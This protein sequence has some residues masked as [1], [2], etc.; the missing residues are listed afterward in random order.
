MKLRLTLVFLVLSILCGW[1]L[2][3]GAALGQ[4][5]PRPEPVIRHPDRYDQDFNGII[6]ALDQLISQEMTSGGAWHERVVVVTLWEPCSQ[7]HLDQ[8]R[9]LG[10]RIGCV[11]THVCYGFAARLPVWAIPH[12][13]RNLGD[14]LCII[15]SPTRG[16][17]CMDVAS[18][19]LR[20]RPIVWDNY[21]FKGDPWSS[22]AVIDTGI[23]TAHNDLGDPDRDN[24]FDDSDDWYD[25][26][27]EYHSW[28]FINAG[29]NESKYK[30]VGWT[31][32]ENVWDQQN[33]DPYDNPVDP[34]CNKDGHGTH[35]S[36]ILS[37]FG[38]VDSNYKGIA[39][40]TRLFGERFDPNDDDYSKNYAEAVAAMDD[41][42]GWRK[43][44]YRIR[45]CNMSWYFHGDESPTL[46]DKADTMAYWG[47][48][49]V[50]SAGNSDQQNYVWDPGRSQMAIT[51]GATNDYD[52]VT[53]YSVSSYP[54]D[55]IKPDVVAPGGSPSNGTKIK[56]CDNN[57]DDAY[58]EMYG[59][60]MAAPMVSGEAALV[61]QALGLGGDASGWDHD[62]NTRKIK[63]LIL[64]T[65]WET[66]AGETQGRT[67][68][69]NRGGKDNIE[70]YGRVCPD[71]AVEAASMTYTVGLTA[72]GGFGSQPE[73]KKVWAR[74]LSF[75]PSNEDCTLRLKMPAYYDADLYV[76]RLDPDEHGEPVILYK[77]TSS[78]EGQT[79][80]IVRP[81][82]DQG[83][84]AYVV[85][86]DATPPP[87]NYSY[88]YDFTLEASTASNKDEVWIKDSDSDD[89]TV[90]CLKTSSCG[91]PS[92]VLW[93]ITPDIRTDPDPPILGLGCEIYVT[94]RNKTDH[95][96]TDATVD[97]YLYEPT[98]DA[99]IPTS[100]ATQTWQKTG[101]T[102]PAEGSVEV[103]PFVWGDVMNNSKG[104]PYWYIGAT[105]T[106]PRD[107]IRLGCLIFGEDNV[108][109]KRIT[110]E[111]LKVDMDPGIPG[112]GGH[113]DIH[114]TLSVP[115]TAMVSA[116]RLA[117]P[118]E[119]G[120]YIYPPLDMP[121]ELGPGETITG[122]M[123]LYPPVSSSMGVPGV[124]DLVSSLI[125]ADDSAEY[126]L[127]GSMTVG[128]CTDE[129]FSDESMSDWIVDSQ[130]TTVYADPGNFV[131]PPCSMRID[132]SPAQ[133]AYAK[134]TSPSI[135][136]DLTK[137]YRLTFSMNW[138][139]LY[140]VKL[141]E[142]GHIRLFVRGQGQP[143]E[144]SPDGDWSH[145][146]PIGPPFDS[147]LPPGVWGDVVVAVDPAM[148]CYKIWVGG[149]EVGTAVY[150][151]WL[152]PVD[153]LQIEDQAASGSVLAANF[154]DIRPVGTPPGVEP[155]VYRSS[156]PSDWINPR[157]NMIS[158]PLDPAGSWDASAIL[159]M[160]PWGHLF[161]WD[162]W[163]KT[164]TY[165]GA[166]FKQMMP[167]EGYKFYTETGIAQPTYLGTKTHRPFE[168]AL[169]KMGWS[170]IGCPSDSPVLLADCE[171]RNETTG[172]T[173]LLKDDRY[174]AD[175]W[176]NWALYW[177]D[178]ANEVWRYAGAVEFPGID[179]SLRPWY[180]YMTWQRTDDITFIVP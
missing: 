170:W 3:S 146:V 173:R 179:D 95:Q 4:D 159:G 81:A 61:L 82:G 134:C 96:I 153:R 132:G 47:T 70:G 174:A 30:V 55:P 15:E 157:W 39:P 164:T 124:I 156:S 8:A 123:Y 60:S 163:L 65:A 71:A 6:D 33:Y 52:E 145:T 14:T 10:G 12:L 20:V 129:E 93:P 98:S 169:P 9:L 40:R 73:D 28:N 165:Y 112:F 116:S 64:M 127:F 108:T 178:S 180:G 110:A 7:W 155:V 154:D 126:N 83:T 161:A 125:P 63:S 45:V 105:V 44:T 104:E 42:L 80:V 37:G 137:P 131:S 162:K 122:E 103:G 85:V 107:P 115:A 77:S 1:M 22:V 150:D 38:S 143:L 113:F 118:P 34:L 144:Y 86:K 130:G 151:R 68:P 166:Q 128:L 51:V 56:S 18:K 101:V 140:E 121:L 62:T 50:V 43:D 79:E 17:L 78:D 114:N 109:A 106:T 92:F 90:S 74:K 135:G 97:V 158:A 32:E 13:A 25:V 69:L 27:G 67:P 120:F 147:M 176:L 75:Y 35:V 29:Y 138:D 5:T 91:G 177:W 36:G 171:L 111:A 152:G 23:D 99:G 142:F 59:T 119:W 2:C 139:A 167:G 16:G 148:F 24:E 53:S 88:R 160:N 46:S 21:C 72:K 168:I 89:G 31:D 57:P 48:L 58:Q 76:Y 172:A 117:I 54:G 149:F 100:S 136:L 94:A 141:L 49:P 87:P 26:D 66:Q 175:P 19:I 41:V 102:I 84:P 11:Y 133:G